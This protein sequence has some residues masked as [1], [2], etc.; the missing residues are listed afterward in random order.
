MSQIKH[1]RHFAQRGAL[2]QSSNK[3]R[4]PG[5]FTLVELLVVIS[6]IALLISLLLPALAEAKRDAETVVCAANL[7]SIGQAMAEYSTT[8]NGAIAGSGWTSAHFSGPTRKEAFQR[9][10]ITDQIIPM[11]W[12]NLIG[13]PH[14]LMK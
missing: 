14:W 11:T 13:C 4:C 6:I 9:R 1:T 8:W 12:P 7:H 3:K 10:P 5:G 2:L